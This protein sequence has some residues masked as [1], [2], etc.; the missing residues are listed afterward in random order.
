MPLECGGQGLFMFGLY[1]KFG[2]FTPTSDIVNFG[3]LP[4]LTR[5]GSMDYLR[6]LARAPFAKARRIM[7]RSA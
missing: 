5:V 6:V 7:G 4:P 1:G 2:G 3:R